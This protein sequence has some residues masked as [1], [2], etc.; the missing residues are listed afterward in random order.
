MK[1]FITGGTGFIGKHLVKKLKGNRRHS[2]LLLSQE[3]LKEIN[4]IKGNLGELNKWANE[5]ERFKPDAAIHLAWES[6][7]NY[8]AETS[9]K[10]LK[11]G[12][13]LIS[14]LAKI[15]CKSFLSSGTCWEYG[16]QSGKLSEDMPLLPF[17][18]F[19]AAKN[20]LHWLGE[21]I[22]RE[23]NMEFIW[24]RIFY[25][26]GPG[27]K[28]TSL[29]PFLINSAKSGKIPEIKT[30]LAKND[31]IFIE[32]VVDALAMLSQKCQASGVYNI[33]SGYSTSVQQIMETV[34]KI[35]NI[36]PRY[37]KVDISE[38]DSVNF[39]ADISKIK[40]TINWKPEV[41]IEEGIYKTI[42]YYQNQRKDNIY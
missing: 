24:T 39:W 37:K 18:A 34:Y 2:L 28:E 25:V 11:Y 41:R 30:P 13:D 32:D 26:Y 17:N 6:L 12:L 29:I 33:G 20:A 38:K 7:P 27:Q 36:Q 23:N 1:I 9:I 31:F 10:N 22:A 42:Q 40:K 35:Y 3:P 16:E 15:G 8:D 4:F 19:S 14:F 21:E 5:I